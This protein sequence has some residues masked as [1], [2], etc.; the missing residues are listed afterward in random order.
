MD[1]NIKLDKDFSKVYVDFQK[2]NID[3]K[4]NVMI[5]EKKI[6]LGWSNSIFNF[7]NTHVIL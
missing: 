7:S 5:S 6:F 4:I 1:I 2:K 3:G